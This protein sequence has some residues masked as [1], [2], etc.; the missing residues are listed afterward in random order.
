MR[1]QAFRKERDSAQ[2][3]GSDYLNLEDASIPS[4]KGAFSE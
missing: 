3:D 1:R 2:F 4:G